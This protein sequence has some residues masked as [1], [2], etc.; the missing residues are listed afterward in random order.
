MS[1]REELTRQAEKCL[2][3]GRMDEAIAQYQALA[4]LTPVDWGLVKQLADLLERSGQREGAARQFARWADHLFAE[5]FHSKAAALYKKVLK[6]E[7]FDEHALWQLGEVSV[8]LKLRADARVAYQRVLEM[9]QRR[10]D[11]AGAAVARERLAAL[12]VA[13]ASAQATSIPPA[14]APA[15]PLEAVAAPPAA[16][17]P[18]APVV[19]TTP[20]PMPRPATLASAAPVIAPTTDV[21]ASAPV[22]SPPT[23]PPAP[24]PPPETVSARLGRL[25]RDAEDAD[26]RRAPDADLKWLSVLE[27][28]PA[29]VAVRLRLVQSAIDRHDLDG[30]ARLAESLDASET[31]SLIVLVDLAHRQRRPNAVE[32]LIADRIHAGAPAQFVLTAVDLLAARDND[33][34]R[35]ALVSAVDTWT[36][37][38][39]PGYAVA[40]LEQ[41]ARRGLLTTRLYL[42]WVEICVDAGLP[43][44]STAQSALARAYLAGGRLAE[45]RAVAEDVFVRDSGAE[46]SRALL[47]DVLD[48][49][50]V[51][52]PHQVLVDLLTPPSERATDEPDAG[53]DGDSAS[54]TLDRGHDTWSFAALPRDSETILAVGTPSLVPC[55]SESVADDSG[56]DITPPILPAEPTPSAVAPA[57]APV[58]EPMFDWADLLG[59]DVAALYG[60]PSLP[61]FAPAPAE[62]ASDLRVAPND[63]VEP[64]RLADVVAPLAADSSEGPSLASDEPPDDL[65]AEGIQTPS[66]DDDSPVVAEDVVPLVGTDFGAPVV[67]ESGDTDR[68][69]DAVPSVISGELSEEADPLGFEEPAAV[70][71]HA[72]VAE[73]V[74]FAA[75]IASVDPVE[76]DLP[77][78]PSV[79]TDPESGEPGAEPVAPAAAAPPP[80][81]DSP[82]QGVFAGPPAPR[83]GDLRGQPFFADDAPL[84]PSFSMPTSWL[85]ESPAPQPPDAPRRRAPGD[86]FFFDDDATPPRWAAPARAAAAA[87]SPQPP[88]EPVPVVAEVPIGRLADDVPT[89]VSVDD[90]SAEVH[91]EVAADVPHAHRAD[92]PE[93]VAVEEEVDLT[94]LLEELKQWDPALPEMQRAPQTTLLADVLTPAPVA[95][96][97][98]DDALASAQVELPSSADEADGDALPDP[99]PVTP[100]D[101]RAEL[102][103]A[104]ADL[105]RHSDDRTVAEQQ[106]AAGRVFLA[107]GLASEAARAF[108]RASAEPRARFE[109]SLSL[110]EL[111]KSRGQLLEAVGWYEQAAMAPVPDAAV[112]R[113]VL[114]DLAESLEA[115]GETDRALGV[116]LDLLSQVEDYRDARARLD[117]LL[118]VDAGG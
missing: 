78:P 23:V 77:E 79:G 62:A 108:E 29:D 33:V 82:P 71:A 1:N 28:E 48:H 26:A 85:S 92:A 36:A 35:A 69:G 98:S 80:Y 53:P 12:D 34:A 45:A 94:Q 67:P 114:Y 56:I 99:V 8:A 47:L 50:G 64:T 42:Q 65:V 40:A 55:S 103:A 91:V 117:R 97:P 31:P 83:I 27:A 4:D 11:A 93:L 22:S 21:A 39:Q 46:P 102:D 49:Q 10:G 63:P 57:T 104:F 113:P 18:S 70:G 111:H 87:T 13:P 14:Y 60:A 72:D 43:G 15:S 16:A 51:A 6:L 101:G 20:P 109:A 118:R 25:R 107:A 37:A 110:G 7:A 115:L 59:R 58:A 76:R 2:R 32:R 95:P 9:R 17:A 86:D 68:E 89:T 105:Q 81:Q 5:G 38:G 61:S 54:S 106:L 73:P 66:A 44:L 41:A 116:L 100:H 30:A 19:A 3:Q 24:V 75:H 74:E 52:A 112:K 84:Q 90:R 88:A 96:A